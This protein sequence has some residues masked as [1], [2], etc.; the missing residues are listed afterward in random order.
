MKDWND[1]RPALI[2][3][4]MAVTVETGIEATYSP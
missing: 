2:M 1:K 3:Q 4:K